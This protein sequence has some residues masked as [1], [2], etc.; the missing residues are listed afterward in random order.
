MVKRLPHPRLPRPPRRSVALGSGLGVLL[1]AAVLARPEMTTFS[2]G[3]TLALL[4]AGLLWDDDHP[5]GGRRVRA[6][7]RHLLAAPAR[8]LLHRA[9][10][11]PAHERGAHA[12]S[13][14]GAG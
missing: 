2:V 1:G 14:G 11:E 5:S 6:R 4:V 9:R 13:A 10:R 3:S 7:A 12:A 8:R